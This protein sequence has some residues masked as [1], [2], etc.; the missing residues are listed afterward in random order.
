VLSIAERV[1]EEL[2]QQVELTA[3][4]VS[5]GA[6]IGCACAEPRISSDRLV[7]WADAAMYESKRDGRGR[8]VLYQ[9]GIT[10]PDSGTR[11][12]GEPDAGGSTADRAG[13]ASRGAPLTTVVADSRTGRRL[14]A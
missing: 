12:T 9:P 7:A 5:L 1:R 10:G 2:H 3:G 8:P 13:P 6:S 11:T 4:T 14:P